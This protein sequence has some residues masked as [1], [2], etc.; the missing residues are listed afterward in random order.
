MNI[1]K[2][3]H[4]VESCSST[5]D[6]ANEM[7]LQ[8][9]EEG[10]VVIADEQTAGKGTKGRIW[11]SKKGIGLYLSVILRPRKRDMSLLPIV[12]GLAMRDALFEKEGLPVELKWPNDL[13]HEG[14]KLGGILCEASFLGNEISHAILGMGLNV[15]HER[16]DFPENFR[17]RATSLKILLENDIDVKTF[18]YRL[19]EILDDWYGFFQEG[20]EIQIIR[21]FEEYS[22]FSLGDVLAVKTEE[23]GITGVYKGIDLR[24]RLLL[25]TEGIERSF[26]ASEVLEIK[27]GF[28]ED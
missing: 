19:W 17:S 25:H 26:L 23:N 22:V 27:K 24:G 28:E 18:L 8:G 16:R 9:A 7:A 13:V 15:N 14:K 2:K 6:L 5:N 11:Y 3:I 10:T 21:A 1:G 12:A 20:K 4:R